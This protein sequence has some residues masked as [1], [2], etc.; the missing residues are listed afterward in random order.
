MKVKDLI[1]KLQKL[2]PELEV[3]YDHEDEGYGDD[4]RPINSLE[5]Q[6]DT[7]YNEDFCVAGK[8]GVRNNWRRGRPAFDD[9]PIKKVLIW[10]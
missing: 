7:I 3:W 2:D 4:M 5:F 1:N 10:K 8:S 9:S 6:T